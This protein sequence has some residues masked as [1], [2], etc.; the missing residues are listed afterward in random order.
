MPRDRRLKAEFWTDE[1]LNR[2]TAGAR[3]LYLA[4][5]NWV[6]DKGRGKGDVGLLRAYAFVS[7]ETVMMK[8]VE[9][10]LAAF[11]TLGRIVRYTVRGESYICIP[12][13]LRHQYIQNPSPSR[14]PAPPRDLLDALDLDCP[15]DPG[16]ER[17]KAEL[18]DDNPWKGRKGE[19]SPDAVNERRGQEAQAREVFDEWC[20]V[21]KKS[22]KAVLSPERKKAVIARLE[23]GFSVE[24]LKQ[25]VYGCRI[26]PHNMGVNDRGMLYNDLELICR[27]AANVERFRDTFLRR[28]EEKR[29][30]DSAGNVDVSALTHERPGGGDLFNSVR[31]GE[32]GEGA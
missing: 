30:E 2:L 11:A 3:L 32:T 10:W 16:G 17:L 15:D 12:R 24:D 22:N 23:Q 25:A 26:T 19:K 7:D 1:K 18:L 31:G 27:N 5:M 20:R 29:M 21:M 8:Q 4:L 28:R 9:E 13:L 6:D 14:L